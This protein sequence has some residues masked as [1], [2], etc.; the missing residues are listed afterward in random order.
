MP[1]PEAQ[2]KDQKQTGPLCGICRKERGKEEQKSKIQLEY[3][4]YFMSRRYSGAV[5]WV[6][7]RCL[8]EIKAHKDPQPPVQLV[9]THCA[10]TNAT[11]TGAILVPRSDLAVVAGRP[12]DSATFGGAL[13]AIEAQH[14][15]RDGLIRE[16]MS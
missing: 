12:T 9:A 16:L 11:C 13:A 8:D 10:C 4:P 2:K 7:G 5:H 1:L 3:G 15:G 14:G 6:F